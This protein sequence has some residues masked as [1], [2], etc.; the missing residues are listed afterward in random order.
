M[1]ICVYGASSQAIDKK[2]ISAVEKLEKKWLC[3]ITVWCSE[4]VQTA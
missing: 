1:N 2:Y 3:A 4:A